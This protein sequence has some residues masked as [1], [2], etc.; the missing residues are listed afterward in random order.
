MSMKIYPFNV[1]DLFGLNLKVYYSYLK[2]YSWKLAGY[3]LMK[4][5][6]YCCSLNIHL[7]SDNS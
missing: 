5:V 4:K 1:A 6:E 3:N 2:G 7:S